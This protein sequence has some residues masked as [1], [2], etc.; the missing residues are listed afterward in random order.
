MLE[1]VHLME[2]SLGK[3]WGHGDRWVQGPVQG[4]R[5]QQGAA[6]VPGRQYEGDGELSE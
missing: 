2:D 5:E 6:G 3:G 4:Y 1:K